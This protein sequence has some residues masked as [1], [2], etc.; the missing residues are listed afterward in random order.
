EQRERPWE[1]KLSKPNK[2]FRVL[3]V[4]D[5]EQSAAILSQILDQWE[6]DHAFVNDCPSCFELLNQKSFDLILIDYYLTSMNGVEVALKIAEQMK[7]K[8][9]PEMV[10]LSP[11]KANID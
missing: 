3:L 2:D 7:G 11:S 8:K 9:I 10:L 4:D 1:L 6:I 5:H